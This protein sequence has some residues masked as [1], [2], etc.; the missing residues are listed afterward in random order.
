MIDTVAVFESAVPS[1]ALN[2]NESDPLKPAA[3]VYVRFGAVPDNVPC[4][5]PET[6][7]VR[8]RVTVGVG[9]RQRHVATGEPASVVT[10]LSAATGAALGLVEMPLAVKTTSS[11]SPSP[12]PCR[13]SN[14][15]SVGPPG[16]SKAS[17]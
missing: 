16:R 3:G 4:V 9:G 13:S 5:G 2:V 11:K 1:F 17:A 15:N 14:E 7:A 6:T 12:P 10:D 8:Q